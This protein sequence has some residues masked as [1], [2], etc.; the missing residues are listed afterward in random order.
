MKKQTFAKGTLAL[1]VCSIIAKGLGGVYRISLTSVLGAEGIGYYQLVFPFFSLVLALLASGVPVT[2]SRLVSGELSADNTGGVRTLLQRSLAYALAAGLL[3]G[4][5]TIALSRLLAGIQSTDGVYI[6]YVAIAPAIVF[7]TLAGVYKGWFL[8]NGNMTTVGVSQVAEVIVKL[9]FGLLAATYFSR[10]GIMQSVAGALLA[11]SL[12]E[13]VGF[14]Y[15]FVRYLFA[16]KDFRRVMPTPVDRRFFK[17]LLPVT[18]SGLV[19]PVVAFIDSVSIVNLL[20]Y[21]GDVRAVTHYGLLTGPVNSLINMPIIFAMSVAV[22]IVPALASSLANYEVVSIKRRTATSVKVCFIIAFPFFAGCAF[23]APE[24]VS[25]LYP[26]LS[27]SDKS[28]T[29]TLMAI[30]A[31]DILLLSLLEVFNA[32]LTGLGRSKPVLVNVA[33]AGSIKI[34]LQVLFAPRFGIVACAFATIAFYSVAMFAN[35]YVYNNLVG[36][37]TI[38]AKSIAKVLFAGV[39]MCVTVFACSFI[40][41]TFIAVIAGALAGGAV[42]IAAI[43]VL[44]ALDS[45]ELRLLPFCKKL[46]ARA[47]GRIHGKEKNTI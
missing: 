47:E 35:A 8:G 3:G 45:D 28:L 43:I 10:Y 31:I 6:C 40:S 44:R 12:G 21:G 27:S 32:V 20:E 9:A 33:T 1:A 15:V 36:K 29:A 19:F 38:L 22:A 4:V 2:V 25:L 37:N 46:A 23:L 42:Y 18:F 39:I 7:V 16:S 17:S 41:D 26:A 13:F 14:L 34:L 11:V 24:I 30:S 5:M